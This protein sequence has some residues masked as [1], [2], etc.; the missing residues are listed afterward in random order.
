VDSVCAVTQTNPD[1]IRNI[2]DSITKKEKQREVVPRYTRLVDKSTGLVYEVGRLWPQMGGDG[3]AVQQE[4]AYESLRLWR[5]EIRLADLKKKIAGT[6]GTVQE[7]AKWQ[8]DAR[9]LEDKAKAA[10]RAVKASRAK[11]QPPPVECEVAGIFF[12]PADEDDGL[13][14][15]WE[16]HGSPFGAYFAAGKGIMAEVEWKNALVEQEWPIAQYYA[17][18]AE[19]REDEEE[20]DDD[21]EEQEDEEKGTETPAPKENAGEDPKANDDG[22]GEDAPSGDDEED[23]DDPFRAAL[24]QQLQGDQK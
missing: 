2:I 9:E 5:D 6:D 16:I 21:G 23:G 24:L 12:L 1:V 15:R 17:L 18:L 4:V 20:E 10:R 13:P 3:G 7:R 8:I 14:A 22:G 11:C 19:R